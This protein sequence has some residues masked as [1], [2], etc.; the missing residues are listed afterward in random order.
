MVA[1]TP[2]RNDLGNDRANLD[3][4]AGRKAGPGEWAAS[5]M[6][7]RLAAPPAAIYNWLAGPP[8]TGRERSRAQLADARN[9]HGKGTL[10]V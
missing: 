3:N 9:A 4:P 6:V 1:S 8:A 10:V 5:R 7:R 2:K